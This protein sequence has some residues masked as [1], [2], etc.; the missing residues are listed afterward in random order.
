MFLHIVGLNH[1]IC[2]EL[3]C[4]H[5]LFTFLFHFFKLLFTFLHIIFHWINWSYTLGQL[6]CEEMNIRF[7]L[8]IFCIIFRT[9]WNQKLHLLIH[10]VHFSRVALL[11]LFTQGEL[12]HQK[13]NLLM[14]LI[15]FILLLFLTFCKLIDKK[16]DLRLVL[17]WYLGVNLFN[18]KLKLI[19]DFFL[20][21]VLGSELRLER[22]DH[23]HQRLVLDG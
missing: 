20:I 5:L 16:R 23:L 11:P 2:L 12:L 17:L 8:L 18:Q 13:L 1:C 9:L 21:S 19:V 7:I 14:H 4:L 6:V 15:F 22:L 10:F 3:R